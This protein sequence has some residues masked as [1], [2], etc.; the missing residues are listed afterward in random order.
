MTAALNSIKFFQVLN[1]SISNHLL[2]LIGFPY[3][4]F[5]FVFF[6][7]IQLLNRNENHFGG[8]RNTASRLI[9]FLAVVSCSTHNLSYR[10]LHFKNRSPP[11]MAQRRIS[12]FPLLKKK[13]KNGFKHLTSVPLPLLL[14]LLFIISHAYGTAP[15][16]QGAAPRETELRSVLKREDPQAHGTCKHTSYFTEHHMHTQLFPYVPQQQQCH[17]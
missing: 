5:F 8:E 9:S 7:W 12:L 4:C 6:T 17:Y 11:I 1:V 15:E 10:V 16:L 2:A 14:L 13:K 3:G